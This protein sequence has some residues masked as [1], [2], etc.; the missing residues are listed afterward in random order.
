M[1]VSP[2]NL[3]A[4]L[5]VVFYGFKNFLTFQMNYHSSEGRPIGVFNDNV[6]HL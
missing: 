6:G 3:G 2:F 4:M 5:A 1:H